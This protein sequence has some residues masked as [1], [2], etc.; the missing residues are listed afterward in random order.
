M[1]MKRSTIFFCFL[2]CLV[3]LF[4]SQ[5]NA[6]ERV[7]GVDTVQEQQGLVLMKQIWKHSATYF[8]RS[9]NEAVPRVIFSDDVAIVGTVWNSNKHKVGTRQVIWPKWVNLAFIDHPS[10]QQKKYKQEVGVYSQ[11]DMLA[12]LLHEWAHYF[13]KTSLKDWQAEGSAQ[14]FVRRVGPQVFK[15][16]PIV[17]D[18]PIFSQDQ[19]PQEMVKAKVLGEKW[20][21]YGQFG[22]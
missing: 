12:M 13:Q 6:L 16:L 22:R 4:V 5:A 11:Q 15:K 18:N 2:I 3:F 8:G 1:N 7:Q 14:L 20:I 19:Y 9:T 21:M 17:F 10:I